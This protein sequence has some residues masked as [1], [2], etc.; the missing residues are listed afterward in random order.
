[1]KQLI[2]R[3]ALPIVMLGTSAVAHA[4]PSPDDVARI[5]EPGVLGLAVLGAAVAVAVAVARKRRK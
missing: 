5:P 1:M 4:Q 2:K 3:L